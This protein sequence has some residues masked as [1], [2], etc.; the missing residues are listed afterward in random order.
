MCGPGEL[1]VTSSPNGTTGA[2]LASGSVSSGP[3]NQG[4]V[5]NYFFAPIDALFDST[6]MPLCLWF[7]ARPC[8]NFAEI[9]PAPLCSVLQLC[10]RV[11]PDSH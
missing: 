3:S 9:S 10:P 2:V 6:Q 4:D 5:V 7:F 1:T 11:S 8:R